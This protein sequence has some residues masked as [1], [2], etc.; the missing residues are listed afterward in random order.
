MASQDADP[1]PKA[2]SVPNRIERIQCK[3]PLTPTGIHSTTTTTTT[4]AA[5]VT[6]RATATT[7]LTQTLTTTNFR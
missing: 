6:V 7:T 5:T 1:I 3:W 4:I 2:Q